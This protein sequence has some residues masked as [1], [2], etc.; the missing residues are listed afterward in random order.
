MKTAKEWL[1]DTRLAHKFEVMISDYDIY[2][3]ELESLAGGF[4][5][6]QLDNMNMAGLEQNEYEA[7]EAFVMTDSKAKAA[8]RMDYSYKWFETLLERAC[9]KIDRMLSVTTKY[10]NFRDVS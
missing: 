10:C 8:M 5:Q 3:G 6:V 9:D 7:C 1:E 2:N 4:W